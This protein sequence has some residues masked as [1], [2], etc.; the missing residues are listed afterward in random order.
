MPDRRELHWN[1][2]WS[3]AEKEHAI[4]SDMPVTWGIART[5]DGRWAAVLQVGTGMSYDKAMLEADKM[6]TI[7]RLR[8]PIRRHRHPV[9]EE[10]DM[11]DDLAVLLVL[12]MTR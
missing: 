9:E 1:I 3:Q 7:A 5:E 10:P 4:L 8:L 2:G 12:L 11:E 6:N